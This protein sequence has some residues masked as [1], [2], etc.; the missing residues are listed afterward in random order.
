MTA[1]G[2]RR[3]TWRCPHCGTSQPEAPRCWVC[4]RPPDTCRT[5]RFF[6]RSISGTI[7]F[8]A[9][10]RARAVL[11]G[12]ESRPCW[13]A[14]PDTA[15]PL[16]GLFADAHAGVRQD[17]APQDEAPQDGASAPRRA[18]AGAA[19]SPGATT[20]PEHDRGT[21]A[22][23][24]VEAPRIG[25]SRRIASLSEELRRARH[26]AGGADARRPPSRADAPPGEVR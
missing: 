14:A 12:E 23:R 5:C 1:S 18:L 19:P 15:E 25:P 8:C 9:L 24:L 20:S 17:E 13:Q 26:L 6:R 16:P 3:S 7:G 10:D 2:A 4:A 11:T 21:A 22:G